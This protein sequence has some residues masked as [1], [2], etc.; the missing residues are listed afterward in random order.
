MTIPKRILNFIASFEIDEDGN[1][2]GL[3]TD[4]INLFSIGKV[5]NMRKASEIEF[6]ELSQLWKVLSLG[7]EVLHTNPNREK[8]IEFEIK[9]FSPGGKYYGVV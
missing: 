7:G 6:D 4:K 9:A 3:Y 1:L 5:I 2:R 8:A